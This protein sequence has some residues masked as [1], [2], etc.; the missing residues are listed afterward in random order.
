MST[1][2]NLTAVM[3]E[4]VIDVKKDTSN[5]DENTSDAEEYD[6][7]AVEGGDG[8]ESTFYEDDCASDAN[9]SA[10]PCKKAHLELIGTFLKPR[11]AHVTW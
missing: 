11:S 8:E 10:L 9:Q 7:E 2:V 5:L 4:R 6:L 1:R 3:E